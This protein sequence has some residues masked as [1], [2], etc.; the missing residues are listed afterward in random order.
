MDSI[1]FVFEII[2]VIAFSLSGALTAMKKEMD[3]FGACVLGMTTAIGGGIIRDLILGVTPPVSFVNPLHATIGLGVAALTYLP[4]IQKFFARNQHRVQALSLMIA[5]S[6][7]LGVFTVV[8]VNACFENIP[9][10]NAFTA[11]FLGV[12]TGV[13]GG[14]LRDVFSMNLPKIFVK[15][16]Y[17]CASI[18]GAIVAYFAHIYFGVLIASISGAIVVITLRFLASFLRW[19]LPKPKY[20]VEKEE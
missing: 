18:A 8:G 10:P 6:V 16:F 11:I 20:P 14:V 12:I 17:A 1:F 13:G 4:K 9:N 5:D 19:N 15:H 7:G 3:I 2:G